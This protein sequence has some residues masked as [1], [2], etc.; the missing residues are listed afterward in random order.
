MAA[1]LHVHNINMHRFDEN[2]SDRL[3]DFKR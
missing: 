1:L 2:L 3:A